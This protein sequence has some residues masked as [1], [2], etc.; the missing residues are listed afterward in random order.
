MKYSTFKELID[1]SGLT[2]EQ[3]ANS[4]NLT[5]RQAIYNMINHPHRMRVD[6]VRRL[7][8]VL[9]KKPSYIFDLI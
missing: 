1:D 4:M 6:Q 2:K 7:A 9:G 3:I 5:S 8:R